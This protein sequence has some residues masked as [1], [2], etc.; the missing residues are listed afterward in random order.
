MKDITSFMTTEAKADMGSGKKRSSR[1][2]LSKIQAK[3]L[4][5]IANLYPALLPSEAATIGINL[6]ADINVIL[7]MRFPDFRAVE[8][9]ENIVQLHQTAYTNAS[10]TI[11]ALPFSRAQVSLGE[12]MLLHGIEEVEVALSEAKH[13]ADMAMNTNIMENDGSFE[14]SPQCTQAQILVYQALAAER[15]SVLL[16]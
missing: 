12:L 6:G 8:I 1:D 4:E 14:K 9:M 3:I 13:H 7:A 5:E 16:V 15:S 11:L 2:T 10:S